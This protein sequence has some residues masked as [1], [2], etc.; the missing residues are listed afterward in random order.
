MA[1]GWY[2]ERGDE[3]VDNIAHH[4]SAQLV[5][6]R[7]IDVGETILNLAIRD[8]S[9]T[10]LSLCHLNFQGVYSFVSIDYGGVPLCVI[11]ATPGHPAVGLYASNS[12]VL[13]GKNMVRDLVALFAFNEK[14]KTW[15]RLPRIMLHLSIPISL[16]IAYQGVPNPLQRVTIIGC[17]FRPQR[18]PSLALHNS[19]SGQSEHSRHATTGPKG[20]QRHITPTHREETRAGHRVIKQ[21]PQIYDYTRMLEIIAVA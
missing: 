8:K 17:T 7:R 4:G 12:V 18:T 3:Y 5:L 14:N 21:M 9:S 19:D 10:P 1:V 20:T 15:E 16:Q 6:G 2:G 11:F 13:R